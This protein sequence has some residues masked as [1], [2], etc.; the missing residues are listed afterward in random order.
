MS[1]M[2]MLRMPPQGPIYR[3]IAG[4]EPGCSRKIGAFATEKLL[5]AMIQ[6]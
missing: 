2:S 6:P 4:K 5:W 1:K 3:R